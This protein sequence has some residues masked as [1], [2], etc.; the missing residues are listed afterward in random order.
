MAGEGVF[1]EEGVEDGFGDEVLGEHF[2]DFVVGDGVVEVV[3]EFGGEALEG[4]DFAFVFGFFEDGVDAGDMGVGDLGD[5]FGPFVPVV[6]VAAFFDDAGVEGAFE[7][8]D[9]ELEFGLFGPRGRLP[10][11]AQCEVVG[12]GF[13]GFFLFGGEGDGWFGGDFVGDGDDFHFGGVG[14]DEF[15]LVDHGV[16]GVVVG[17]EG[18]EDFPDDFVDLVVVEGFGGVHA[19]GDDDGEDDVAAFFAGGVAHDA[20]DGLDDIDLGVA[21]GEEEDGVE[22]G[23]VHAFGEAADVGEDAAGVVGRVGLEPGEL[24]LFFGGVHGAVDVLGLADEGVFEFGFVGVVGFDD[25]LEH[26]G[27]LLGAD[28]VGGGGAFAS[29]GVD[30]LAEGDGAAHGAAGVF[31]AAADAV[32]AEGLPAADD[33]G[34]VVD[35]ELVVVVFEE[36]LEAVADV[37]GVDGED[38]DLVVGEEAELDGF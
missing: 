10:G 14:A 2:H 17:A 19:G 11:R 28:L 22:G 21:G 13:G 33:A 29:G 34:G 30:D 37:F 3:A 26:G 31:D 12:F 5:V 18:L 1:L 38:D 24:G 15:Q 4:G 23:H 27:D 32:F 7:F 8:A 35:F 36:V 6:A 9:V 20:S 25:L 16:E